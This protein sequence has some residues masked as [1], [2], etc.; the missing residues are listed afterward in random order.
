MQV[1]VQAYDYHGQPQTGGTDPIVVRLSNAVGHESA[2]S[3]RLT[4]LGDGRYEVSLLPVS[5]G[6]HRLSID[7]LS[8]P[9]R[10][11]PFHIPVKLRQRPTWHIHEGMLFS[12]IFPS[13]Q[14]YWP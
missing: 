2:D 5:P 10:G 7:I 13:N 4:D 6:P 3:P 11:S 9:I 12:L 1:L 8:R 14:V